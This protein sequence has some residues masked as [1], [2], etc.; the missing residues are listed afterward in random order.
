M[1]VINI[2]TT[3]MEDKDK[4]EGMDDCSCMGCKARGMFNGKTGCGWG[5]HWHSLIRLFFLIIL[6]A[7]VFSMGVKLGEFKSEFRGSYGRGYYGD[8][9]GRGMMYPDGNY[10]YGMMPGYLNGIPQASTTPR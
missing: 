2:K 9:R 6:V 4:K 1:K 3:Y 7:L 10:Y 5:W 8:F